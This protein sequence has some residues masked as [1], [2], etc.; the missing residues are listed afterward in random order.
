MYLSERSCKDKLWWAA[1]EARCY[2]SRKCPKLGWEA[3]YQKNE[4]RS[5]QSRVFPGAGC[6]GQV[7]E[8]R[9]RGTTW[10]RRLYHRR[11]QT[12]GS[13]CCWG[14]C[15]ANPLLHKPSHCSAM[16]VC[17]EWQCL[18]TAPRGEPPNDI[19]W[20]S[21]N[22]HHYIR[23]WKQKTLIAIVILGL[24]CNKTHNPSVTAEPERKMVYC[25]RI[26]K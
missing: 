21:L 15:E 26:K 6:W 3:G 4:D 5:Q 11:C 13:R 18:G 22:P 10:Q 8:K 24:K 16:L 14:K 20:L 23:K 25:R 9:T 2:T 7:R 12:R 17:G 1:W 19:R